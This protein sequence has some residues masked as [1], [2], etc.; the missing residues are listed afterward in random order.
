[1]KDMGKNIQRQRKARGWTQQMLADKVGTRQVWI[2]Q[3]ETGGHR[4]SL[5][6][7]EKIAK[8]LK[9]PVARLLS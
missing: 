7:L 3:I 5:R 1:M 4:P 2:A 6:M 8:A 9:V